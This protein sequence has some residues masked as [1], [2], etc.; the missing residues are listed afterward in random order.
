MKPQP[1]HV[2]ILKFP[3]D[4]LRAIIRGSQMN[5]ANRSPVATGHS[6]R[7]HQIESRNG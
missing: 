2:A 6:A 5:S 4:E 1:F 7:F 3:A